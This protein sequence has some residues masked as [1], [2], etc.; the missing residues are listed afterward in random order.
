MVAFYVFPIDVVSATITTPFISEVYPAPISGEKEWVEITNPT[1]QIATISGWLLYDQISSPSL[2]YTVGIIEMMPWQALSFDLVSEKLNNSGD[3]VVLFNEAGIEMDRLAYYSTIQGKS[4]QRIDKLSEPFL[5][6]PTKNQAVIVPKNTPLPSPTSITNIPSITPLPTPNPTLS[7][8][9]YFETIR[10]ISITEIMACPPS[11]QQEWVELY[12]SAQM[13]LS[14][15]G[16][17]VA[18]SQGNR[19]YLDGEIPAQS[20]H[21][22]YWQKSMLNNQGDSITLFT[23]SHEEIISIDIPQCK[24]GESYSLIHG[25]FENI[26]SPSPGQFNQPQ[27]Q[28]ISSHSTPPT[29]VPNQSPTPDSTVIQFIPTVPTV[30]LESIQLTYQTSSIPIQL[31]QTAK[32]NLFVWSS[33]IINLISLLATYAYFHA[34]N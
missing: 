18:D 20:F 13:L 3:A 2:I 26:D 14:I 23:N 1:D 6:L 15:Q 9:A 8:N 11:G 32:P 17:Y 33:V 34:F 4:W 5:D 25:E 12:N 7:E 22:S 31:V 24:S 21:V 27:T 29:A 10:S 16:W 28:Q 30:T 19:V